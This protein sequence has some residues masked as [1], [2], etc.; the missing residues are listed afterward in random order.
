[1]AV[2]DIRGTNGAGKSW[3]VHRLMEKYGAE[4]LYPQCSNRKRYVPYSRKHGRA[5]LARELKIPLGRVV[6]VVNR[7]G[8][9]HTK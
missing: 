8:W 4:P 2:L 3:I 5:A 7:G 9:K 1:M 6:Y